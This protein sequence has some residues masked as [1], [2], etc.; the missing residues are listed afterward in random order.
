MTAWA[1]A[2]DVAIDPDELA[3]NSFEIE[4]PPHSGRLQAFPEIDRVEWFDLQEARHRIRP[5]QVPFID[6]LEDQLAEQPG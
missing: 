6:R 3:S 2:G 5:A 1:V 4:W